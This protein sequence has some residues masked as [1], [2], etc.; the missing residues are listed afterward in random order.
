MAELNIGIGLSSVGQPF[1]KALHTVARLGATGVEI[2]V[3]NSAWP[4]E[5]T[6]TGRRQLR[7]MLDDLNLRVAAVR[8][9]TRRGYDVL[10]D[11]DRRI[12]ATKQTMRFAYSLGTRVVINSVGYVPDSAEHPAYAQLRESLGDLAR[13]GQHVGAMLACETA[14]EPVER[15]V[16]LLD[17][18]EEKA[19]GIAFNPGN[20]IINDCYDQNSIK[21]CAERT[22]VV[23]ARDGVRDLAR[24]RGLQV[25]LGRGS[26]EFPDILGVLE[27]WHYSGWFILESSNNT[28]DRESELT[29][30]VKFLKAL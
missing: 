10:Q 15:L 9:S 27:E 14:S 8:F 22:L 12:D 20:L 7:K 11:L 19:I 4:K 30:A 13:Y 2:D 21:E 17:S 1:K 25:P 6:D 3:R 16:G 23:V 26:A 28:I 29:N 5:L 18:L 24:G